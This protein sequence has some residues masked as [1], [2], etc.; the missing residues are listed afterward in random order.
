[1]IGG[2]RW[3]AKCQRERTCEAAADAVDKAREETEVSAAVADLME[4][5]GA[6]DDNGWGTDLS[7]WRKWE[8]VGDPMTWNVR[9]R[10]WE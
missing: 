8:L 6:V 4:R 1:M 9:R 7:W 5:R 10:G 2:A 3:R